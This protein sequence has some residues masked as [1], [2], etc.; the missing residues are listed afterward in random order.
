M[1]VIAENEIKNL[2]AA[3]LF[4]ISQKN[5]PN[6]SCIFFEHLL[7]YYHQEWKLLFRTRYMLKCQLGSPGNNK[8]IL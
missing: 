5:S 7:I 6:R 1:L 8:H 4:Y 2:H 3:M